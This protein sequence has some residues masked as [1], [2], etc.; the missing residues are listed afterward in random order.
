MKN[1]QKGF[2]E[3]V[4]MILISGLLFLLVAGLCV[5][6]KNFSKLQDATTEEEIKT[7]CTNDWYKDKAINNLP[8][9]CLKYF[10]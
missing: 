5:D 8:A 9:Q 6:F 7:I 1:K 4:F 3:I 2:I 10:K